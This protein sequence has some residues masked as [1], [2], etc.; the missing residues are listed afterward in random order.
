MAEAANPHGLYPISI[1]DIYKVFLH[2]EMLWMGAYG[3]TL[4]AIT[5]VQ[6]GVNFRENRVWPSLCDVAVPWLRLKSPLNASHIHIGCIQSV[7][8]P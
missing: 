6:V 2:L 3:Y 5:R 7:L 4:I 8:A 1:L